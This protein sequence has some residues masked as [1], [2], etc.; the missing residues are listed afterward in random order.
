[1][2]EADPRRGYPVGELALLKRVATS[3]AGSDSHHLLHRQ[4]E[5]FTVADTSCSGRALDR[6]DHL[7]GH[8]VR[9]DN[10][11]FD[12][13]QEVD[14]VFRPSI[15]L[16]MP[17]LATKSLDFADS[18]ALDSDTRQCLFDLIELERLYDSLNF[19]HVTPRG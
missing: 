10:F 12:L 4:Y 9:H 5:Y 3:L 19:L 11:E 2:A 17:F 7:S 13:G 1:M 14:D 18:E 8:F 15:K 16:G 6:L